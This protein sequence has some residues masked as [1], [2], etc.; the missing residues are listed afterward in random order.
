MVVL[1]CLLARITLITTVTILSA[2]FNQLEMKMIC[3]RKHVL[4]FDSTIIEIH[5]ICTKLSKVKEK[6]N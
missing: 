5:S 3:G 6:K 2:T 4:K 1:M